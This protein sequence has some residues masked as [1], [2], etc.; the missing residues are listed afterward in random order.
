MGQL[1][2]ND[3]GNFLGVNGFF[4]EA[5]NDLKTS[6][7]DTITKWVDKGKEAVG[8][9]TD[10]GTEQGGTPAP[11]PPTPPEAKKSNTLLYVSLGGAAI[12]LGWL[13][14]RKPKKKGK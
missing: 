2:Q 4:D 5:Y 12:L 7:S 3:A 11:T 13:I 1:T 9:T 6:A 10:K 14:F 8:L